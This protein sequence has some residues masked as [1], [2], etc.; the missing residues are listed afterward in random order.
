[1]AW[2]PLLALVLMADDGKPHDEINPVFRE[3]C[4]EG[5]RISDTFVLT[6]REPTMADGLDAASQQ[7]IVKQIAGKAHPVAR[8]LRSSPVA[9]HIMA[10]R[11]IEE[12][13]APARAADAWFV[14]YGDLETVADQALLDRLLSSEDDEDAAGAGKDLTPSDL[15][16]RGIEIAPEN[17]DREAFAHGTYALVKRV[18]VEGTIRSFWTRTADSIVAAVVLDHRFS[19][20]AEF[21]NRWRAR[22]RA[23]SGEVELGPAHPY[24]GMGMYM[25][26]TRLI[27]PKG[28]LFV[29]WHVV[30]SEPHGWFDGANLLGSK[31][32]AIVQ[33][34]VRALRRELVTAGKATR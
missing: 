1:M 32:P 26:M 16:P 23:R 31:L 13:G 15:A 19:D 7:E 9:P 34:R 5:V 24:Q 29:E 8:F 27:E 11:E 2:L 22:G 20:D 10:M 25:K 14:A 18:D 30:F 28:A 6:L 21:P 3:L 4:R 33:S 12:H 17:R